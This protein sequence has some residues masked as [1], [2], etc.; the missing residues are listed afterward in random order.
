MPSQSVLTQPD[1][2]LELTRRLH[3]SALAHSR[4]WSLPD[5]NVMCCT[6]TWEIDPNNIS[7]FKERVDAVPTSLVSRVQREN[8]RTSTG[9]SDCFL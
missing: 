2:G 4:P 9:S 1:G 5:I 7:I 3:F 8:A 6:I